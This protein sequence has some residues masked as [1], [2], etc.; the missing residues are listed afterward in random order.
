M[1]DTVTTTEPHAE[2]HLTTLAE[3]PLPKDNDTEFDT[4]GSRIEISNEIE[5]ILASFEADGD[6][7]GNKFEKIFVRLKH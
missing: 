6:V 3:S 4:P 5:K 1:I 7:D 2:T